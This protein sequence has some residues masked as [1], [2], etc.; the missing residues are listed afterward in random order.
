M[1]SNDDLYVAAYNAL[2]ESAA[3]GAPFAS[4]NLISAL[5]QTLQLEKYQDGGSYDAAFPRHVERMPYS[6]PHG[7]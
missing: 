7:D 4:C 1:W 5:P 2:A 6:L 3:S